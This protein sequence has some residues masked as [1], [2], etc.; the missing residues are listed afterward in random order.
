[1]ARE[2]I[3]TRLESVQAVPV[4]PEEQ[5][6]DSLGDNTLSYRPINRPPMAILVIIDDGLN[7]GETVR[8][9]SERVSIGREG[10]IVEI[11]HDALVSRMH[12]EI[13]RL[14]DRGRYR[15]FLE[16]CG[17]RNGTFVRVSKMKLAHEQEFLIG[18]K[19]F[20]Y[21]QSGNAT[22][23]AETTADSR[24]AATVMWQK[25]SKH[26]V[27]AQLRRLVERLPDDGDGQVLVID[28]DEIVL[29]NS[30]SLPNPIN[31]P[32]INPV[33]A[34]IHRSENGDWII[35]D[36]KSKNGIWVKVKKLELVARCE[37][38]VGE[39]RILFQPPS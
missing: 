25:V 2:R 9:R 22:P 29:G 24:P 15:W 32:Y 38:Q 13:I 33:H 16:D 18:T 17:S 28:G 31:D 19:R 26:Q 37:F 6:T 36:M 34:K 12:A 27:D 20:R 1:M 21:L 35:E 23:S 14:N 10:T 11:P 7:S 39:Q 5:P 4:S 30:R 8:L 3:P